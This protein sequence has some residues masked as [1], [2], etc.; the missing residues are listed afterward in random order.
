MASGDTIDEPGGARFMVAGPLVLDRQDQ[1]AWLADDRLD[2]G[3]KP[4]LL[5]QEL[6][7]QPGLLVTKDRLFDVGWPGQATSDAVLTTAIRD[8]RRALGDSTRAPEWI[9]T[10]HGK[11][12]RFIKPVEEHAAHPARAGSVLN[13]EA[14]TTAPVARARN[15]WPIGVALLTLLA[16]AAIAT[17]YATRNSQTGTGEATSQQQSLPRVAVLPFTVDGGAQW[18]GSAMSSRLAEVLQKSPN[19]FVADGQMA[20]KIASADDPLAAASAD[21]IGTLVDGQ[22]DLDN[23]RLHVDVRVKDRRGNIVWSKQFT[24]SESNLLSL[25]ERLT[26]ETVRAMNIASDPERMNEMATLGTSSLAAFEAYS[27]AAGILDSLEAFRNPGRIGTA[28]GELERAVA[29]D[30][31]FSK[32]SVTLAWFTFPPPFSPDARQAEAKALALLQMGERHAANRWDRE[33]TRAQIDLRM[34]RFGRARSQLLAL[35]E[36]TRRTSVDTNHSILLML[37]KVAMA[38]RDRKLA[39]FVWDELTEYNL[40]RGRIQMSDP[41]QIA[42]DRRRL[43]QFAGY[44]AQQEPTP[45][46][47]YRQH[48]ALLLAGKAGQAAR[49]LR[50]DKVLSG[51][52]YGV[53]ADVAQAC[54]DGQV[55]KARMR[56]QAELAGQGTSPYVRWKVGEIAGLSA[57]A[58]QS[59]PPADGDAGQRAIANMLAEPG[60]DPRGYP[61]LVKAMEDAGVSSAPLPRPESYCP[62]AE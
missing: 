49:L 21:D 39:E 9:E 24:D 32:A 22:V 37:G 11:G 36:E 1:R 38:T 30:P 18:L 56:A 41:V 27:N 28:I 57:R 40:A 60:F 62:I 10:Q 14:A 6:M 17:W 15:W 29:L 26:F 7:R 16:V 5:L 25:I 45:A 53:I 34:L 46:G 47:T 20:Q 8:L 54:A 51:S 43:E 48:S 58:R 50:G 3:G 31:T 42:H 59:L 13:G 2:I 23:G 52:P 35:Y 12:Y 61:V 33:I 44:Q 4:L 19:L 55:G